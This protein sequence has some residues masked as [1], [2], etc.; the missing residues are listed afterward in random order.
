MAAYFKAMSSEWLKLSRSRIWLQVLLSPVLALAIGILSGN[1]GSQLPW[2]VLVGTMAS[3][4]ALLFLP[5]LT[6]VFG[7]M[8]CRYEHLGGGWKQLLVTPVSRGAVY[9]AKLSVVAVLM[10]AVQLLFLGAVFAA[11]WHHG[12]QAPVPWEMI[13]TSLLGGWAACLPL[14]ALQLFVSTA[15]SSFAAPLA[16]NVIFTIPNMLIANSQT[17]GPYY[18]WTQPL[19]AMAPSTENDF[20]AFLVPFETLM[21]VVIGGFLL[22]FVSGMIYFQRK[23][24]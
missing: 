24:V 17:Y 2:H 8:V 19:L 16:L 4:H 18:P 13:A 1:P 10:G 5:I 20:G 21:L 11:G 3:M 23:E 15:W 22:F 7:A 9:C 6:G 14:A 12:V